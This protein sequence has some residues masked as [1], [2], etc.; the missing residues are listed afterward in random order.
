MV[1]PALH[2]YIVSRFDLCAK[3]NVLSLSLSLS[4]CLHMKDGTAFT[5]IVLNLF[6][7]LKA[8]F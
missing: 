8:K 7:E 1:R 5:K 2:V 6:Y 4:A 3:M